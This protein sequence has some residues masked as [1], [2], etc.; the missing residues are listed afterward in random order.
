[1]T[2]L[3]SPAELSDDFGGI[4]IAQTGRGHRNSDPGASAKRLST[5]VTV[6]AYVQGDVTCKQWT[7]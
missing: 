4:S 1:L 3:P 2:R 7:S 6:D 5:D